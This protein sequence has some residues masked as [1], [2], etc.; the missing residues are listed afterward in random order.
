VG[1]YSISFFFTLFDL[2]FGHQIL[3]LHFIEITL[4]IRLWQTWRNLY[5]RV[6]KLQITQNRIKSTQIVSTL[7]THY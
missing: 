1:S 3:L 7:Q 6:K 2:Y 5:I 4:D